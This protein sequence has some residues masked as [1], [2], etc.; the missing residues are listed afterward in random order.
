VITK[1]AEAAASDEV[2]MAIAGHV[3]R[4]MLSRYAHIRTE[5]KRTALEAITKSATLPSEK[6]T[7]TAS[8]N[9]NQQGGGT[10]TGTDQLECTEAE[11]QPAAILLSRR[12]PGS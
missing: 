9:E 6:S 1:L 7:E 5:A 11:T 8:A 2:V 12:L 10:N 4:R 3:N